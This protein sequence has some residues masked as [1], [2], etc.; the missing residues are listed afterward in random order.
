MLVGLIRT[1]ALLGAAI[2]ILS[3]Q[4]FA[5]SSGNSFY[6]GR[7]I[8]LI[9]PSSAGGGYDLYG[10]LIAQFIGQHI[11]G[12]P[13]VVPVNM[14]GAAGLV[15]ARYIHDTA[16]QDGTVL[17][18]FY[19][20]AL[21]DPILNNQS[22]VTFDPTSFQ[23]VGS[24]NSE[25]FICFLSARAPIRTMKEGMTTPVILG[26]SGIGGF[27]TDYPAMYNN[28]LGTK[29]K[30]VNGYPGINEI[31]LAIE[32]GEID[33][34]CG[35]SWSVMTTGRPQWLRDGTMRL[36]AQENAEANPEIARLGAP[37]TTSYARNYGDRAIMEFFYSQSRFGRP[38]GMGP[39]VPAE[40]VALIREAFARTLADPA[41][42]AEAEKLHLEINRPMS[43]IEVQ[44]AI[45]EIVHMAPDIVNAAKA[46]LRPPQQ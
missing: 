17:A 19:S 37:L 44:R 43:G 20:T 23:Y 9:I 31:G 15:T 6:L 1:F 24:A 28:L 16:P 32:K 26:A 7:Q 40:R 22:S 36:L 18:L 11:P 29:F 39:K 38:F 45:D 13:P 8:Q 5:Q 3:G 30:I 4:A 12:N 35:A 42:Q 14:P 34:T 10:R 41:F 33:G 25:S 46:A 2:A 27:S 21:L